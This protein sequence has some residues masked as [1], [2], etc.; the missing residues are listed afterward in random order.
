MAEEPGAEPPGAKE[1]AVLQCRGGYVHF[2]PRV[3][4]RLQLRPPVQR[5]FCTLH[6]E[7]AAG[8]SVLAVTGSK[9][10]LRSDSKT[11]PSLFAIG[12]QLVNIANQ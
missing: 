9:V 3:W 7:Q 8:L 12:C 6:R 2:L 10:C 5:T 11:L 4:H 1:V